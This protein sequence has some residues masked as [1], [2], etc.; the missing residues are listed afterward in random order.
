MRTGDQVA[1][2]EARRG[3]SGFSSGFW[4]LNKVIDKYYLGYRIESTKLVFRHT[5]P[6]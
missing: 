6:I 2:T 5:D 3:C 4:R 1:R